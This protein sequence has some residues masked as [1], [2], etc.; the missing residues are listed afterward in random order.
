MN[1]S[2]T[3]TVA[4][5]A[6][7]DNFADWLKTEMK[8]NGVTSVQL[9]KAIGYERKAVLLWTSAKASPKLD[10]V[11]AIFSYFGKN[12]IEIEINPR[13]EIDPRR[14]GEGDL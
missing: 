14:Y 12:R 13:I 4:T 5:V 8:K 1:K 10:T 9:A 3:P 6:A 11:A 7:A 2:I